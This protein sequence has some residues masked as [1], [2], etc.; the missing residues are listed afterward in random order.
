MTNAQT[1]E[2]IRKCGDR[3]RELSHDAYAELA[4]KACGAG[5]IVESSVRTAKAD[6]ERRFRNLICARVLRYLAG[7]RL[8][9][10]GRSPGW[11]PGAAP[12]VAANLRPTAS[13]PQPPTKNLQQAAKRLWTREPGDESECGVDVHGLDLV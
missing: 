13:S 2:L 10:V 9:T 6:P 12:L 5:P 8:E 4:A 1:D 11:T 3:L 7:E